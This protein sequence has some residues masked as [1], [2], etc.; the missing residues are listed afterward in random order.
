M[1]PR[2]LRLALIVSGSGTTMA[3]II[4][5]CLNGILQGLV[6]P[7]LIVATEAGIGAIGRALELVFPAERI[8]VC[9]PTQFKSRELF[10][11]E[12]IRLFQTYKVNQIGLHGCT[13]ILPPNVVRAF[14]GHIINQHPGALRRNHVDFGKLYGRQV[15]Y[16]AWL[17][18]RRSCRSRNQFVEASAQF[19]D[20]GIDTGV[21]VGRK[22]I[23]ILPDDDEN[24][25]RQRLILVEYKLQILVLQ[26]AA[27]G[28]P[29]PLHFE[30][31]LIDEDEQEL[32]KQ[33]KAE[34]RLKY[35]F[36]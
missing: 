36:G 8:V 27:L 11:Q 30:S 23:P 22:R 24:T 25:L 18:A 9:D 12:L 2:P 16:A 33:C 1:T 4:I 19:V 32:L 3:V 13:V 20:D 5:A 28:V 15:V 17:F 6:E 7:I 26:S 35:P 31:H 29:L 14:A 21:V 10:G 34:A